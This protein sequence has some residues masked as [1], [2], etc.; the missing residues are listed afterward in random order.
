MEKSQFAGALGQAAYE[1]A[2]DGNN[3]D[4][5][6]KC[7]PDINP[8]EI[9]AGVN[10]IREWLNN[11]Q[12][13]LQQV[14]VRIEPICDTQSLGAA[15]GGGLIPVPMRRSSLGTSLLNFADELEGVNLQLQMLLQ[16][17]AL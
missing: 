1:R 5:R 4:A 6:N 11:V 14:R 3:F 12:D 9:T 16:S 7:A 17:I 2:M 10:R 8:N 15:A 13:S